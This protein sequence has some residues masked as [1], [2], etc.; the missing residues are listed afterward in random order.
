MPSLLPPHRPQQPREESARILVAAGITQPVC[1]L[2]V[3]GYFFQTM[4]DPGRN[5]RGIYD[6]AMILYSTAA[7]VTFNANTDPSVFRPGVASLRCG[8]W[9]YK[10]GIHGLSKPKAKQYTALVQ[11]APVTVSRDP[12]KPGNKPVTDTGL[13]GINIHRGSYGGTSSLGCQTIHPDQWPAFI[14]LVQEQL[15]RFGQKTIPYLLTEH[16]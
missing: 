2:G 15:R 10:V 12:Q 5:D 11:A 16:A 13:F 3:R 6:D 4:G 1:L 8:L 14:A 7:H 9:S